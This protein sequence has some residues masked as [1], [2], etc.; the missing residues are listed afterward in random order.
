VHLSSKSLLFVHRELWQFKVVIQQNISETLHTTNN[1]TSKAF[2]KSH[3]FMAAWKTRL[4]QI[5]E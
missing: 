5:D 3:R 1:S 4:F 2:A